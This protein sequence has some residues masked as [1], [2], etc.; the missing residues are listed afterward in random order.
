MKRIVTTIAAVAAISLA[1]EIV[2]RVSIDLDKSGGIV[3]ISIEQVESG[4]SADEIRK[5]EMAKRRAEL[6]TQ[7]ESLQAELDLIPEESPAEIEE[8]TETEE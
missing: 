2:T 8:P 3:G 5:A 1:A 7:I 4:P 6:I